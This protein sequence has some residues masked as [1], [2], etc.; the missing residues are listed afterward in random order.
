MTCNRLVVFSMSLEST[1]KLSTGD[2]PNARMF[3]L[4][5]NVHCFTFLLVRL[6]SFFIIFFATG[7][8]SL[9]EHSDLGTLRSLQRSRLVHVKR[10][11][12]A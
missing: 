9:F 5:E 4:I 2:A 11:V 12:A 10:A 1:Y 7:S 8:S 6:V 3:D